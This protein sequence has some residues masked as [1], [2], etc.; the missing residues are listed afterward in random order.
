MDAFFASVE[1]QSNPTLKGKP[2]A[3]T[4]AGKR[5]IITT[6]SYEARA[7]GVKTGM[8]LHEAKKLCPHIIFV[9]GD[10]K[11]Y[12][13]IR[14]RL[15]EICLRFTPDIEIYK[16]MKKMTS[17]PSFSTTLSVD[18]MYYHVAQ[19]NF[20]AAKMASKEIVKAEKGFAKLRNAEER[21]L[22]RYTKGDSLRAYDQLEPI[23]IQMENAE[24]SI[25]AAYGLQVQYLALTHI[26]CAA[27]AEPH[28]NQ[29][30]PSHKL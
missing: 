10:N 8:T 25:A 21:I 15:E 28:I 3:V 27:S 18:E 2:I 11:K 14:G 23:Y 26:L 1:Q 6:A 24:Y 19:D 16:I 12:A 9:I 4:G 5:T 22:D 13:Y 17:P 7:Y 20:N 30:G 29:I